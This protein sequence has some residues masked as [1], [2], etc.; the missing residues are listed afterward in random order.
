MFH[1]ILPYVP[2]Q[3]SLS[4]GNLLLLC[5]KLLLI[6]LIYLFIYLFVCLFIYLFIEHVEW[7]TEREIEFQTGPAVSAEPNVELN[8]TTPRS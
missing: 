4:I 3:V 1:N 5:N 7:Q 2:K 6:Y 8:H